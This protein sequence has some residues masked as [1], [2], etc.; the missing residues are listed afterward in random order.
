MPRK[1]A[2]SKVSWEQY[3]F[4]RGTDSKLFVRLTGLIND[5]HRNPF[6]GIGKPEPLKRRTAWSRRL[7]GKNRIVYEVSD[8]QL[9][10]VSCRGHYD[11]K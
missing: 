9:F 1:I 10:V 8:A 7:D 6:S 5:C 3:H 4:W 11:D 2:F